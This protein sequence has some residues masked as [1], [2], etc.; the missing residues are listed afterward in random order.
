MCLR[1]GGNLKTWREKK[2]FSVL[3][4]FQFIWACRETAA[5]E[6]SLAPSLGYFGWEESFGRV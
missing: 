5:L 4:D 3:V 2:A 1:N 6:C